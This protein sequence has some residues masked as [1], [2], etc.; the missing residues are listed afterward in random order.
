MYRGCDVPAKPPEGK[1]LDLSAHHDAAGEALYWVALEIYGVEL[2]DEIIEAALVSAEVVG[3]AGIVRNA[4]KWRCR[5]LIPTLDNEP[6]TFEFTVD[7][8]P[9]S[10]SYNDD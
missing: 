4:S 2:H 8:G 6:I 9:E 10:G 7:E 1:T 3:A 5:T